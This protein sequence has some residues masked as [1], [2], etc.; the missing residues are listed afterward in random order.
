MGETAL[1][2]G[3][4]EENLH[5]LWGSVSIFWVNAEILIKGAS[6]RSALYSGIAS[7]NLLEV[8]C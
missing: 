6:D 7:E 4:N 1:G 3:A 5:D 8:H 2:E